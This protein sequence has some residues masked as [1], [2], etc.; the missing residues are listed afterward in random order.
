MGVF[1][2]PH[3]QIA[4]RDPSA[5]TLL[6]IGDSRLPEFQQ[7]Y[8]FSVRNASQVALRADI[9]EAV[10]RPAS[11]VRCV[12]VARNHRHPFDAAA[13]EPLESLYRH[14]TWIDLLGP[15]CEGMR[16]ATTKESLRIAWHRWECVLRNRLCE[17]SD[18]GDRLPT[19][20]PE[21]P[22]APKDQFGKGAPNREMKHADHPSVAVIAS[23]YDMAQTYLDLAD[24]EG[25]TSFWCNTADSLRVRSVRAAWWDDSLAEPTTFQGWRQRLSQFE[26]MSRPMRHVWI[27]HGGRLEDQQAAIRAGI[28]AV[29]TKPYGV[30]SLLDS[31]HANESTVQREGWRRAA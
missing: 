10:L 6:W 11:D 23:D 3:S 18:S 27:T 24:S 14:A 28:A 9:R 15:L 30:E 29:I 12:I 4:T 25:V 31:L 1:A 26:R 13:I 2:V 5:G 21:N 16:A 20:V 19:G 7:A 22:S 17:S 8:W